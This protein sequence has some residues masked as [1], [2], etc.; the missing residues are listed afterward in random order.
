MKKWYARIP[1]DPYAINLYPKKDT[2][3]SARDA[4]G[5]WLGWSTPISN[6]IEIWCTNEQG[7]SKDYQG[8]YSD[9]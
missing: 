6:K 8:K 5:D 2:I 7:S 3:E 9:N 1:G 4:L